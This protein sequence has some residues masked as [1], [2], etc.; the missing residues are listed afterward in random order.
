MVPLAEYSRDQLRVLSDQ[1]GLQY[2][3]RAQG[4]LQLFRTQRQL[5]KTAKDIE[6]LK[7]F[8]FPFELLDLDGLRQ[9]RGR[10]VCLARQDR[11]RLRLPNDD[12]GDC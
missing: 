8:S 9:G 6:V 7:T 10:A 11:R 2:D 4:T 1:L 5:D 3:Q 12:T